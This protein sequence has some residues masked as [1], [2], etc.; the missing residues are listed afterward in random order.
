MKNRIYALFIISFF[1]NTLAP[2]SLFADPP[3]RYSNPCREPYLAHAID[4]LNL[5]NEIAS[6]F[7]AVQAQNVRAHQS[8]VGWQKIPTYASTAV[9]SS[10]TGALLGLI[11]LSAG[12]AVTVTLVGETTVGTSQTALLTIIVSVGGAVGSA[13]GFVGMST[14]LSSSSRDHLL[15][16]QK[17][18]REQITR[19]IPEISTESLARIVEEFVG[20]TFVDAHNEISRLHEQTLASIEDRWWTFG[21]DDLRY[22][23]AQLIEAESHRVLYEKEM[24]FSDNLEKEIVHL[25]ALMTAE[26]KSK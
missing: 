22:L 24:R 21:W 8:D 19:D 7:E 14:L 5:R 18:A 20:A 13:S 17:L 3:T 15:H 10:A 11:G 16:F 6:T 1:V 4:Y 12:A 9:I 2:L 26:S 25:C 23:E